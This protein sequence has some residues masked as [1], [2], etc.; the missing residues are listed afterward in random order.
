MILITASRGTYRIKTHSEGL[1]KNKS[2]CAK[3]IN[4]IELLVYKAL[5]K[6]RFGCEVHFFG[7]TLA[8]FYI[9]TEDANYDGKFNTYDEF[10]SNEENLCDLVGALKSD[11]GKFWK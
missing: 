6:L 4:A 11:Q 5:E 1:L 8:H 10:L 3:L 7:K 2:V 9:A